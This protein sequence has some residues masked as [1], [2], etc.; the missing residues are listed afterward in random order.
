M[1]MKKWSVSRSSNCW[2][3][4]MLAPPSKSMRVTLATCGG[5][6]GG[7]RGGA[8]DGAGHGPTSKVVCPYAEIGVVVRIAERAAEYAT[9][10]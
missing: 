3:S 2:L 1:R 5:L 10:A 8:G 4:S 9:K 7:Q 6:H